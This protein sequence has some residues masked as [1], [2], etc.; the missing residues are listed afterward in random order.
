LLA[1][2]GKFGHCPGSDGR[3]MLCPCVS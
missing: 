2:A 3:M 1:L